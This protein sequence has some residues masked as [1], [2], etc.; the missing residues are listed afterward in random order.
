MA[1]SAFQ[2]LVSFVAQ[3]DVSGT[4][5]TTIS[6]TNRACVHPFGGTL[7]DCVWSNEVTTPAIRPFSIYLPL[8]LRGD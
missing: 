1:A 6:V 5:G 8:A 7:G 4:A 2:V 3:V